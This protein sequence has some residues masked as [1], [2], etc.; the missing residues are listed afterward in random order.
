MDARAALQRAVEELARQ[1]AEI[2]ALRRDKTDPIAVVGMACRL[3]GGADTPDAFWNVLDGGTD[4]VDEVPRDRWN[5]EAF[6]DADPSVSGKMS[7]RS[8]AFINGADRFDPQ[9]FGISPREAQTMDPQQR[10][11][12]EVVWEAL[13]NANIPPT[14][15]YGS[16]TGVF[17]GITCFDHA[18]RLSQ[19]IE[20]FSSYAGTGSALNM[21]PG[22]VSYVL[23][24]T[25]PSMAIDTAC[26][27]SLVGLHLACQ[28]LRQ[29]ES[30]MALAGGVHLML[31]PEV[32]VS[33]SQARMLAPDGRSKTFDA[34]ADGYSRGEGCGIVVLKRYAD[35]VADRNAILGLIRGTAVNQDGPSGGL[36]VPN[37]ASQREVIRRALASA[38]V[39]PADVTYVEA[40]GTGTSLGDP[41]E[42]EA[43][44][45]AYGAGRTASNPLLIGS[46]KTNI[47]HLEPAAGA[48][49]LIKLLLALQ[50]ERIPPHLHVRTP[51][52]HI[53]WEALPVKIVSSAEAWP[54]AERPRLAG[55]SAFGF[56][57]TNAH[58]IVQEAPA[59]SGARVS[60]GAKAPGERC[61]LF[62]LSA[63]TDEALTAV[64]V[65]YVEWLRASPPSDLAAL[66]YTAGSGRSHFPHRLAVVAADV[67]EVVHALEAFKER[68]EAPG[69]VHGRASNADYRR[70]AR[71]LHA[72]LATA[73]AQ[74]CEAPDRREPLAALAQLYVE[75]ATLEWD[76]IMAPVPPPRIQLPNHPFVRQRYWLETKPIVEDGAAPL[77]RYE[78]EWERLGP[79]PPAPHAPLPRRWAIVSDSHPLADRV[80]RLLDASGS[81]STLVEKACDTAGL[82]ATDILL[83]HGAGGG[84]RSA[85]D[86]CVELLA[87]AQ[88]L[89]RGQGA[90]PRLWIVTQGTAPV[91]GTLE[92]SSV[93]C[94][95]VAAFA[96]VLGL[97]HPELFAR[98]I[99]LDPNGGVDAVAEALT[100]EILRQDDEDHVALRGGDRYAPRIAR[101]G[102]GSGAPVAVRADAAYLITGGLGALGLHVAEWL[103]GRGAR[104][105]CLAGRRAAAAGAQRERVAALEARGVRVR[106]ASV[107]VADRAAVAALLQ[108]LADSAAP[109]AGVVHAAGVGGYADIAHLTADALRAVLRPK[110]D[111]AWNLHELTRGLP[112]DFFLVFSSIA[113][114]WG[115][116]G[117]AHYAAA[118]GFLDALTFARRAEGLP[119]VTI[120][121]GPWAE[122]GM[123][124]VEAETLLR[125][126]GVRPLPTRGAIAA[127]DTLA[128]SD[129]PQAIIA[130]VE[131]PLFTGSYEARGH[132]R[133]LERLHAPREPSAS[134]PRVS[135]LSERLAAA[136]DGDRER[137]V[138][139]L[140]AA[141]VAQ[142]LGLPAASRPD[143]DQGLFEMGMDSLMALELRTRLETRAG[144]ALPATL[145]FD[146]PAIRAIARLLLEHTGAPA[147]RPAV[148]APGF[149]ARA[150]ARG[151]APEP[152]LDLAALSDADAE[153]LLLSKLESLE[154][155][156]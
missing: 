60:N 36:T 4:T 43:L 41:I 100:S 5:A 142:V 107:D 119:A 96:K 66:C 108:E 38:G 135:E 102:A 3:P 84:P 18:I 79:P 49:G 40:H 122:G 121:W 19:A 132:R 68:R 106:I 28:S 90:A 16:L 10:I 77:S 76:E 113:S 14:S 89:L 126:V 59:P 117:Q 131:W 56:S 148:Q 35:A 94:A 1:R 103:A 53:A 73:Y 133:L 146:Y 47:G 20:N 48:A 147:S 17:V 80:R 22:R 153:A 61:S 109:L 125:R 13:E 39:A 111:G 72:Q 64:V 74:H 104:H 85:A 52:P 27:S 141:D 37:G 46:A 69:V 145:V 129:R 130:D 123:N 9:F 29:R 57:G 140:V 115:S 7:T 152:P 95:P 136:A 50:H 97:E 88:T 71:A 75:G 44:A 92:L 91:G 110:V 63:K 24:L 124:S 55:L 120:N 2:E 87:L 105:L 99:D 58:V 25:G 116:R 78:I 62:A 144:R 155:I 15:L 51:N 151:A 6:Y 45:H 143:P 11:L 150:A 67:E 34:S 93:A 134:A 21:A 98:L 23:G 30:D 156:E 26:S 81:P 54:R 42:V 112:L 12:L 149:A 101:G 118:N 33:F 128:A 154:S 139:G 127:L 137:T 65:R 70:D 8:G 114:A 138:I 32:M 82:D 31:S 86:A 83:I